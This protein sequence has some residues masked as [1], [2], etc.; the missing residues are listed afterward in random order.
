MTAPSPCLSEQAHLSIAWLLYSS[1]SAPL[2]HKMGFF[3]TFY[4]DKEKYRRDREHLPVDE[5]IK[6]HQSRTSSITGNAAGAVA[7]L[8]HAPITG[9]VGLAHA[10]YH[11]RQV[12]VAEQQQK[13]LED[14]IEERGYEIPRT[15]KRDVAKGLTY[16]GAKRAVTKLIE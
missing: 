10:G 3:D 1:Q 12:S 2:P 5:L 4:F 15:R 6:Q 11:A 7:G 16:Y 9:P 14:M 8:S 13:V